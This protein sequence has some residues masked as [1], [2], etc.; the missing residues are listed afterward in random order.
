LLLKK[1]AQ[2]IKHF[3]KAKKSSL[4]GVA[5]WHRIRLWNRRSSVQIPPGCKVFRALCNAGICNIICT[6]MACVWAQ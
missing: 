5:K 6:V 3:L 2:V 4:I 1:N